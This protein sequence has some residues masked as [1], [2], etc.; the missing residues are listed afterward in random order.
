MYWNT[1]HSTHYQLNPIL[2]ISLPILSMDY[3]E[4][5]PRQ[6]NTS[7]LNISTRVFK[8]QKLSKCPN[9]PNNVFISLYGFFVSGS[10]WG[11]YIIVYWHISLV[12]FKLWVLPPFPSLPPP[13]P[14]NLF[15][16]ITESFILWFPS[17]N[18]GD[19]ILMVSFIVLV[20]PIKWSRNQTT[21]IQA[22]K[23]RLLLF[24]N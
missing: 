4:V 22:H 14:C 12:S 1:H 13:T 3:F 23:I 19:C 11:P 2:S 8:Q 5:N 9:F 21:K 7:S 16:G 10:R 18:F 20:F 15:V 24:F 6:H 17:L